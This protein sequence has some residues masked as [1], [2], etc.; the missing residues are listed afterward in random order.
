[1]RAIKFNKGLKIIKNYPVPKPQEGEALIKIL[2]AGIC[3][4]DIEITKGYMGFSGILGHEFVGIVEKINDPNQE[5]LNQRVVG[6]INC[7]CGY[8]EYCLKDLENH[9]PKRT[10]LGIFNRNGCFADYITLPVKNLHKVSD[11]ITNREAVFTE[12]LAAAFEILEQIQINP[13]DK[14]LIL[15]DGK[16]GLLISFVLNLTLGEVI[17]VGKHQEKLDIAKNQGVKVKL[18]NNLS[19]EKIY[20]VV[21]E[22]TGSVS[23]FELAQNLVKPRGTIVLK[24]TLA[25]EKP[26]NLAPIVIDEIKIIG[27]RCG[28]FKPTLKVLE[29]KLIDVTPLISGE[30]NFNE[31][32]RAFELSKTTG[33]LK[34]LINF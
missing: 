5:L 33:I 27:S 34:V 21:V 7:G 32:Q 11:N 18:L 22:A 12:P 6:E 9:C 31:A 13:D 30:F 23:G 10:V 17:L 3:N 29:Q 1:M 24:S 14:V 26:L 28:P 16:L 25:S 19:V 8:C 20:D 2:T 15:G 4:T